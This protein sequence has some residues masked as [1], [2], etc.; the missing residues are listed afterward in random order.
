MKGH[1]TW[2][3]TK[4]HD[5]HLNPGGH[6]STWKTNKGASPASTE[7]YSIRPSYSEDGITPYVDGNKAEFRYMD[8]HITAMGHYHY[9]VRAPSYGSSTK[10]AATGGGTKMRDK[11]QVR[12]KVI[13]GTFEIF[14][15]KIS[16]TWKPQ[17]L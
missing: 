10:L 6:F 9:I 1:C 7:N 13:R 15:T 16:R 11:V 14:R 5:G 12:P 8:T 4:R 3:G 2:D 17:E